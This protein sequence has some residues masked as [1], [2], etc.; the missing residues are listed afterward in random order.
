MDEAER[1]TA[2]L[3][4]RDE[5]SEADFGEPPSSPY[6]APDRTVDQ[7]TKRKF[8]LPILRHCFIQLKIRQSLDRDE[9]FLITPSLIS[10]EDALDTGYTSGEIVDLDENGGACGSAIAPLRLSC[11]LIASPLRYGRR[12]ADFPSVWEMM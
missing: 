1:L 8:T 9:C 2:Q 11:L 5:G 3:P 6:S 4:N 7:S 10:R 12:L